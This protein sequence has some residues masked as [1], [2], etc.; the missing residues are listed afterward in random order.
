MFRASRSPSAAACRRLSWRRPAGVSCFAAVSWRAADAK[1]P[2]FIRS[3]HPGD[4]DFPCN[5]VVQ[6]ALRGRGAG[7]EWK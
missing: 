3:M 4:G 6:C 7:D 2:P 1:A 5:H